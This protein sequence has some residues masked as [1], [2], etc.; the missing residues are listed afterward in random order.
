MARTTLRAGTSAAAALAAAIALALAAWSGSSWYAAAHDESAAFA[1]ARDKALSAGEQAVQNLNTLDHRHLESGLDAWEDSTTGDLR[2]ELREGRKA[3]EEEVRAARTVTTAK[4]LSG[5]LS[6]LDER[7]GRASV[8]IAL[9]IT[10]D[11]PDEKPS[12]KVSRLLGELTRTGGGWKL[13]GLAQAPT[14]ET[15]AGN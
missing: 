1:T 7:S 13:S 10:V 6:E 5:A 15:A 4:V 12:S 8:L 9:R 2:E 11:A 14:G 3:F